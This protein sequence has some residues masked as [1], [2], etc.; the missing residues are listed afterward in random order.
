MT[1]MFWP[2]C[3]LSAIN[4][5]QTNRSD[6]FSTGGSSGVGGS[7][8]QVGVSG[9]SGAD[10]VDA[11]AAGT[12]SKHPEHCP[13]DRLDAGAAPVGHENLPWVGIC[14]AYC[15]KAQDSALEAAYGDIELCLGAY[16]KADCADGYCRV[17]AGSAILGQEPDTWT[18]QAGS[19]PRTVNFSHD[20]LVQQNSMT[21]AEW[22]ALVPKDPSGYFF[23]LTA[24]Y[25]ANQPTPGRGA[26][27]CEE[28]S[29]PVNY[30]SGLAAMAYANLKSQKE[31]LEPCYLFEG[32]TSELG[33]KAFNVAKLYYRY[34]KLEDCPGYRLPTTAE[35]ERYS[36]AG[37]RADTYGG[38]I[39]PHN[40]GLFCP[41]RDRALEQIGWYCG[42]APDMTARPVGQLEP[43]AFGLFDTLGNLG[44]LTNSATP[45]SVYPEG[46]TDPEVLVRIYPES[47]AYEHI[48]KKSGHAGGVPL[49]MAASYQG[50]AFRLYKPTELSGFRLVRTVSWAGGGPPSIFVHEGDRVQLS[51][52]PVGA[53]F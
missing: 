52:V 32:K 43:N 11:G 36:R 3:L 13:Q 46:I 26:G 18:L 8:S 6:T 7:G 22:A 10:S 40:I 37:S 27:T 28:P 15:Y 53:V 21:R 9:T 39:Q 1:K 14:E 25:L 12:P 19:K 31:G 5:S 44:D 49:S 2:F 30:M 16:P 35:Q 38:N 45:P 42:N 41:D 50:A 24:N 34:E 33:D 23:S 29:C 47:L 51:E 20:I 4:C 48:S 17:A